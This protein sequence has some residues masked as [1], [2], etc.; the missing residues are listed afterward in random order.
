MGL[1]GKDRSELKLIWIGDKL[2]ITQIMATVKMN[3][4]IFC[5]ETRYAT[6]LLTETNLG[7]TY[8]DV[9]RARFGQTAFQGPLALY[10]EFP[11]EPC[12]Q[13]SGKKQGLPVS[14]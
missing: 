2:V 6:M 1:T 12:V 5:L 11:R 13:H 3:S 8:L 7:K 4:S 14:H 9:V 10:T